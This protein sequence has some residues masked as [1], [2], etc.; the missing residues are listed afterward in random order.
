MKFRE[1]KCQIVP[2]RKKNPM[3]Q[4]RLQPDSPESSFAGKDFGVL[5]HKKATAFGSN[6]QECSQHIEGNYSSSLINIC[7]N[8]SGL[9][10]PHTSW[11]LFSLEGVH[12]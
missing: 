2:F 10:C 1:M 11:I 4:Y 3:H 5:V 12:Y 9:L 7:E 8:T 6:E